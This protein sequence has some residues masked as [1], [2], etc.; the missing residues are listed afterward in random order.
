MGTA[1][2]RPSFDE[3]KTRESLQKC[4]VASKSISKLEPFTENNIVAK[5]TGGKGISPIYYNDILKKF[6][7]KRY[8]VNY[9][10]DE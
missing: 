1:N 10:I 8:N 7:S 9:I 4:L 3:L 6:A 5:R 2:K